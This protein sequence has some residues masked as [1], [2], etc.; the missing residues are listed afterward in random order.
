MAKTY[1]MADELKTLGAVAS[2]APVQKSTRYQK[3]DAPVSAKPD[4]LGKG[5]YGRYDKTV[6]TPEQQQSVDAYHA[7]K[8]K[9]K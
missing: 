4:M 3:Y 2:E 8:G 6:L 7:S 5:K 1:G 9:I